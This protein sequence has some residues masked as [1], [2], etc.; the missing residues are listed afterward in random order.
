MDFNK[1]SKRLI[2]GNAQI[3]ETGR[4][5]KLKKQECGAAK[6]GGAVALDAAED[7]AAPADDEVEECFAILRR[8]K[9]AVRYFDERGKEWREALEQA[10]IVVGDGGGGG[11]AAKSCEEETHERGWDLN[12]AAPEA[13]ESGGS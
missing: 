3:P 12:V 5:K 10:E 1:R 13:A 9:K 7:A 6:G 8:M 2:I 4:L 11:E